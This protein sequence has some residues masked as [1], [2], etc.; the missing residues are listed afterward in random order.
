MSAY[1]PTWQRT[2]HYLQPPERGALGLWQVMVCA[3]LLFI[4]PFSNTV[5]TNQIY[6]QNL[7]IYVTK[8]KHAKYVNMWCLIYFVWWLC[9][10]HSKMRT[11]LG[12]FILFGVILIPCVDE[13]RWKMFILSLFLCS[14]KYIFLIYLF[15]L[16]YCLYSS[17]LIF[18][19]SDN[20]NAF[21]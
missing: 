2:K 12:Y 7:F 10:H 14:N 6:D 20:S 21:F 13:E 3:V 15:M 1:W 5:D 18:N 17:S 4:L 8:G 19:C 16:K 9:L 11:S